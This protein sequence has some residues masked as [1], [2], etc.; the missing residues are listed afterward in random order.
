MTERNPTGENDE[1]LAKARERFKAARDYW[2]KI[3]KPAKEDFEFYGGEQ[4]PVNIRNQREADQANPRPILTINRLPQFHNQI[5]NSYRQS[6]LSMKA[7]G[8]EDH[9]VETARI[10]EG[11]FRQIEKQSFAQV[12]YIKGISDAVIGCMGYIRVVGEYRDNTS[13]DQD[14]FIKREI[15]PFRHFPDPRAVEFF[16][17]DS[18]FWFVVDTV[19][20][21]AYEKG[22]EY[23]DFD[24]TDFVTDDEY[25]SDWRSDTSREVTVAE[26][27]YF[28][29][30]KTKLHEY[31]DGSTGSDEDL[32]Q[33]PEAD[34]EELKKNIKRSRTVEKKVLKWCK[35]D[36]YNILEEAIVWAAPR[37][38]IA[39]VWGNELWIGDK[40]VVKGI[41]RD[42]KDS[43]RMYNY[44]QTAKTEMIALAPKAPYVAAVGQLEG[45]LADDWRNAAHTPKSVLFYKPVTV[46]GHLA[47]APQR[48]TYEAPVQAIIQASMQS[49]DDIKASIGMYDA[50]LGMQ[51][52]EVSGKAITARKAQGSTAT[53]NFTDNLAMTI[54]YIGLICAEV[55][56]TYYDTRET[57]R[58]IGEDGKASTVKINQEGAP[59][60]ATAKYDLVLDAGPSY[61][62]QR[63][64]TSALL[65]E[66]ARQ[67]PKL[68]DIAGDIAIRNMDIADAGEIATRLK[69]TL[70]PQVV[71]DDADPET[72]LAAASQTIEQ[73]KSALAA[74]Q[75][76]I[77]ELNQSNTMQEA[78]LK[79]KSGELKIR[80][81][82]VN[83]KM[84]EAEA[85]LIT[86]GAAAAS[87]KENASAGA[88]VADALK[89]LQELGGRFDGL[90]D[91]M[92][93]ISGGMTPPQ[94]Q[95]APQGASAPEGAE[96]A[97][98]DEAAEPT[99]DDE[100]GN[101]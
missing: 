55:I 52:N 80:Q 49:S 5:V 67:Y 1:F 96:N 32:Q 94:P 33:L 38:P 63:E 76:K 66:L 82:E 78:Q 85:K 77:G 81:Q 10:Y 90:Y 21:S 97:S 95:I 44:Y 70:P 3:Y 43:C 62:T 18:K 61:A 69:R 39:P 99:A 83:I 89:A 9:D 73:M 47:P 25:R 68:W 11:I 45:R 48:V 41:T 64:E 29:N 28:D 93:A 42:A 4:W 35:I 50:S 91:A 13:F 87:S 101:Q 58:I 15:N 2:D 100:E 79:D 7:V 56:P 37:I 57:A 6:S 26:Y 88:L 30:E 27:F 84:K 98:E 12:A 65:V 36:G 71:G 19:P 17:E 53:Y 14:L 22:G 20:E 92:E 46:D 23:E 74:A 24:P 86:A 60:I 8:Q 51:G 59:D 40:R 34:R 31:N 75:E 16:L 54:G 72:K